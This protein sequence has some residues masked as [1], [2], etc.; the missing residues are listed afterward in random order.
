[1]PSQICLPVERLPPECGESAGVLG[2]F[3]KPLYLDKRR[4]G[5]RSDGP[6]I[7]RGAFGVR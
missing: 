1:L 5:P 4:A 7:Q 2:R 3:L 6:K